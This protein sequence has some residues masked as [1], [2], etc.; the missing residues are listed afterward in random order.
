MKYLMGIDI[1][2][3]SAKA[4]LVDEN[5]KVIATKNNELPLS[6]PKPLWSEQDPV[7]WWNGIVK[8]IQELLKETAIESA[9]IAAI[10]LTGQMHGLTML[11]GEGKVLRPAILWNDQRTGK[12]CTDIIETIGKE[13]F[14]QTTGNIA[15]TGFTA[16]KILWVK[17]NDPDSF[18]KCEHILLPKDYVRFKLTGEYASDRAGGS[19]TVLFD[20]KERDWSLETVKALKIPVSWLPK[21]YE[22]TQVT[23]TISAEAAALT[24]LAEGTPVVGGGGDQAAGAVGMGAVAPGIVSLTLGTSGVIF[25]TTDGPFIEKDGRLHAFCHAMPDRWHLMGVMLSA[26]GS[27]KWYHDNLAPQSSYDDFLADTAQIPAGSEGLYFLPYLTG[28]RTPYPDPLA[29]G[30]FIGLTIRHTVPH[31]TRAVLEG[32]AFGLRDSFE[33][34]KKTGL[35]D[36]KQVRV[37]G[38]GAKSPIWR[39]ILADVLNAE[40]VT[41]NTTEGGAFGAT[42]CA[43]VGAGFWEDI[44]QA[45]GATISLTGT[46]KPNPESVA[47]YEKYYQVYAGLYN[48]LKD[49][50]VKIHEVDNS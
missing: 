18:A 23:G 20:L 50:F 42:L 13:K 36:V 28:E 16:P 11:D 1:S 49:T 22:G 21:T 4:L 9:D 2:T 46:T 45:C 32:V 43:G 31:M 14:L 15:L 48:T 41:V 26:A 27:L 5:G 17:Q 44:D 6:T 40:L 10:G 8:S 24:G 47:K 38:G 12:Q 29:R 3:T 37:S 35:S 7:D 30:G 33:L 19:G 39:Q 34:M 25:A